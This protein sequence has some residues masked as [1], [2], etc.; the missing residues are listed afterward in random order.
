MF[1]RVP[2]TVYRAAPELSHPAGF[3]ARAATD[4]R[5]SFAIAWRLF[6][7]GLRARHRRSLLG[8]VWLFVPAAAATAICVYLQSHR[9]FGVGPTALPYAVHVLAGMVLW[10][11]F[12]DA[13]NAPLQQ[14]SASRQMIGRTPV[15]HEAVVL[16]GVFEVALNALVRLVVL[17]VVILAF[18]IVPAPSAALLPL[19]MVSLALLGLAL[20]LFAAPLGLLYDDVRSGLLLVA[21]VWFFLTPIIYPPTGSGLL[22]FNPVTPLIETGRGWILGPGTA[23]GFFLV[24]GL[25]LLG[26]IAAWFVYRLARPHVVARLG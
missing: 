14:L 15:P 23:P 7:A 1:R 12:V 25:S 3:F 5:R 2:E 22:R 18:G 21:T 26:L 16:G 9:V 11:V 24:V 20:G 17:A 19:A 13:L 4:L 8:Y 6:G 10:Q